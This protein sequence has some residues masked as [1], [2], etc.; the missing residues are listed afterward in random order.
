MALCCRRVLVPHSR[1]LI[2]IVSRVPCTA[3]RSIRDN[4]FHHK[5]RTVVELRIDFGSWINVITEVPAK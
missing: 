2:A 3:C 5:N 4:D 1:H